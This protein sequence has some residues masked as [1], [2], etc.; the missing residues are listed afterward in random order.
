M[1]LRITISII[2]FS[3]VSILTTESTAQTYLSE[4]TVKVEH[5]QGK[6]KDLVSELEINTG[7]TFAYLDESLQNKQISLGQPSWQMDD[8]LKEVSVQA[9]VSVKRVGGSIAVADAEK[10]KKFPQLIDESVS[11]W[12]V[13]GSVF[14]EN[15]LGMPSAS[16]LLLDASD[17]S[18][19][20]GAIADD[21]GRFLI[22][23]VDPGTY[24]IQG[25]MVG[26]SEGYSG[27]FEVKD[28]HVSIETLELSESTEELDEVII[29]TQKPLFE[30]RIDRLVINVEGSPLMAGGTLA[31]A[32]WKLP[33]LA[34]NP[35]ENGYNI[36]GKP[37]VVVMINNKVRPMSP[38]ESLFYL[39]SIPTQSVSRIELITTPPAEFDADGIAGIIHIVLKENDH[40]GVDGSY[41]IG[42]G[43]GGREGILA[44][45][46]INYQSGDL[47]VFGNLLFDHLGYYDIS[48]TIVK[49]QNNEYLFHSNSASTEEEVNDK[50]SFGL[51]AEYDLGPGTTIGL[52]G[53]FYVRASRSET[54]INSTYLINPGID[55]LANGKRWNNNPRGFA[56]VNFNLQ[57]K[58]GH[59]QNLAFYVDYLLFTNDQ[60][61]H[62]VNQLFPQNNDRP[63]SEDIRVS[64]VNPTEIRVGRLDYEFELS[65]QLHLKAGVKASV[66]THSNEIRTKRL[67]GNRYFDDQ[68]F[69]FFS[70][71]EENVLAAYGS[72][73]TYLGTT[74]IKSGLRYERTITKLWGKTQDDL[75]YRNFGNFFPNLLIEQKLTNEISATISFTSRINRPKFLQFSPSPVFTDPRTFKNGNN[76]LLPTMT[77]SLQ[78]TFAWKQLILSFEFNQIN[79]DI[80]RNPRIGGGS[81][82]VAIYPINFKSSQIA[83]F[84][85]SYPLIITDWWEMSSNVGVFH[86]GVESDQ[87]M[88]LQRLSKKYVMGNNIQ[89]FQL[90]KEFSGELIVNYASGNVLGLTEISPRGNISIGIMKEFGDNAGSLSLNLFNVLNSNR[91]RSR[92]INDVDNLIYIH[93]QLDARRGIGVSYTNTFGSTKSKTRKRSSLEELKR[94]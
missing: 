18:F 21:Q 31:G 30:R 15:V 63:I 62:F 12:S 2:I 55:T 92:S 69:S 47:N 64:K 33:G 88:E 89:R 84:R 51:G 25:R 66:N 91:R 53:D 48:N 61:Q 70:D 86:K 28:H 45:G 81:N 78:T 72:I 19:V 35:L 74:R 50:I 82:W 57:Q 24:L 58:I 38:E 52:T 4:I 76:Q 67:E 7:F 59:R 27:P 16:I 9:G 94:L 90:G 87:W 68:T 60:T 93:N 23:N 1:N 37:G 10:D 41:S 17:S 44:G 6:L 36:N 13:T 80:W 54:D 3:V 26:F 43:Y 83:G 22:S 5:Q 11:R 65:E 42:V 49:L 34:L 32:L 75:I 71:M 14:T 20:R 79:N 39:Q 46:N 77:R 85:L 29:E 40:E 8:L 56:A 73:N